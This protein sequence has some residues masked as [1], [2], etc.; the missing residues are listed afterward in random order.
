MK[1]QN[2]L[3]T[4]ETGFQPEVMQATRKKKNNTIATG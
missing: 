2:Y 3:K 1:N 4:V